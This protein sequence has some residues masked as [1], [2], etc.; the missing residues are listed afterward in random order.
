MSFRRFVYFCALCGGWAAF[1]GW[2]VGRSVPGQNL[3][4]QAGVKGMYLGLFIGLGLGAVDAVWSLSGRRLQMRAVA[5]VVLALL[6]GGVGGV[7]GGVVGQ[8]LYGRSGMS[9]SLVF[10][11]AVTGLLIGTAPGAFDLLDRVARRES[12]RGALRKVRNGALGGLAGG[13]L[14]GVLFLRAKGWWGAALGDRDIDRMWS[15]SAT[16]FVALGSC[17]GLAF[18]LAQVI[19]KQAWLRVDAGFRAGRELIVSKP[20]T[21]IGRAEACDIGLF[22]DPG[23]ELVHA[24]VLL[25]PDGC[26]LSDAGTPG[27]TYLN[28]Q[29]VG[30]PVPL[31][32]GD[33]ISIG[34]CRLSFGERRNRPA[35]A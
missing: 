23:V 35:G 3:V 4:S 25:G 7:M 2:A 30:E 19:F 29:R 5:K 24:R 20:E 34:K 9:A 27:G 28:G 13:L 10:S 11:W 1:V 33:V 32:S 22:G 14:G 6:V 12:V 17:I 18:G 15:P 21:T 31:R 8:L 26:M 16:G